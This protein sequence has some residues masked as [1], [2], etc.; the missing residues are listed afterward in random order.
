MISQVSKSR[1]GAATI[2]TRTSGQR[3]SLVMGNSTLKRKRFPTILLSTMPA[4]AICLLR[5]ALIMGRPCLERSLFGV[6]PP[7]FCNG[8]ELHTFFSPQRRKAQNK[9]RFPELKTESALGWLSSPGRLRKLLLR[10]WI[11]DICRRYSRTRDCLECKKTAITSF[12]NLDNRYCLCL[13]SIVAMGNRFP[14]SGLDSAD[15]L[16]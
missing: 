8:V 7:R 12:G 5:K 13:C 2:G 11:G 1:P 6:N 3:P 9:W 4:R 15:E 10:R 14:K 16:P